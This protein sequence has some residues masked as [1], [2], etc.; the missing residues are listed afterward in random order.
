[1]ER[2]LPPLDRDCHAVLDYGQIKLFSLAE[3]SVAVSGQP[4]AVEDDSP[5]AA[6]FSYELLES[7]SV[8]PLT[9]APEQS[10]AADE[11]PDT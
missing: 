10:G 2:N 7:G 11:A 5:S 6:P 3:E 9:V 4:G 1:M 8:A